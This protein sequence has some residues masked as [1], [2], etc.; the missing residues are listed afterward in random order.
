[1]EKVTVEETREALH[2]HHITRWP[3]RPCSMCGVP[4]TYYFE[5]DKI[6]LDTNCACVTYTTP[7]QDKTVE[8]FIAGTFNLQ[9]P[10]VR[11]KM[12]ERFLAAGMPPDPGPET[13]PA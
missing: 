10:E 12:W 8:E 4:I 3:I 5:D 11:E 13:P 6:Q 2:E 9:E 7:R 1:M